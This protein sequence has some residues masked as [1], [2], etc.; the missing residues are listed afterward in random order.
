MFIEGDARSGRS[1]KWWDMQGKER[2]GSYVDGG[3]GKSVRMGG[4]SMHGRV[5]LSEAG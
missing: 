4:C 3:G 5:H 1:K 2:W